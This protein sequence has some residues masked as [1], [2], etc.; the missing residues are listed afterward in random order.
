VDAE[1]GI[2]GGHCFGRTT[3][4][5]RFLASPRGRTSFEPLVAANDL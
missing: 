1:A 2:L 3:F 5:A 4:S